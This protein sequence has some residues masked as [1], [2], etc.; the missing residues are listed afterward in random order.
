[1]M[2][3]YDFIGHR[4]K[5]FTLSAVIIVVGILFM[6]FRGFNLGIDFTGGSILERGFEREVTAQ[7]I[8]SVLADSELAD[9]GLGGSV[10]Q[11][12]GDKTDA[13]IRTKTLTNDEIQQVDSALESAFGQVDARR[14][15]VVGPVIGAELIRNA[16][17]AIV[18]GWLGILVYVS[19]RFEYRFGVAAIL[20]VIH[21]V[22]VVMGLFA[23]IGREINSPFVAALLTVVGYSIN[24]TIVIFDRIRENLRYRKRE[25]W[26]EVANKSIN[27]SLARSINTSLTTLVVIIALFLFGGESIKD[28]V[29]A[30]LFGVAVGT[31]SSIFF[32]SPVWVWWKERDDQRQK[33]AARA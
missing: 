17:L 19:I 2:R 24:D 11:L 6:L 31:Y 21:D 15:E 30:L 22:L 25:S 29:L 14:T 27:Q 32:A 10:V 1:M 4:K 33:A 5:W 16:M 3:E 9:L 7:Q 12:L 23:I 8:K 13:I 26:A 20:A 28:F 18:I